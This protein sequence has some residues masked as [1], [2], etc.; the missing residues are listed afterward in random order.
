[1]KKR[2]RGVM[3]ALVCVGLVAALNP[4]VLRDVGLI[5]LNGDSQTGRR[6]FYFARGQWLADARTIVEAIHYLVDS[7]MAGPARPALPPI[8]PIATN[9]IGTAHRGPIET[10]PQGV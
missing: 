4:G 1:M 9:F 5:G 7:S 10:K 2:I 6:N 3:A 8:Q